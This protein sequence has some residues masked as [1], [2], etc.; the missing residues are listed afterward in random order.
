MIIRAGAIFTYFKTKQRDDI[1]YI[2]V[3]LCV[4]PL[5]SPQFEFQE[6]QTYCETMSGTYDAVPR[7]V[8]E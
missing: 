3:Y 5:A 7:W 1:Y 4:G 8:Y 6:L 2:W